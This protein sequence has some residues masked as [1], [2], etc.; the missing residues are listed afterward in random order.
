MLLGTPL[1]F[2]MK[3][4]RMKK[5]RVNHSK[6][7]KGGGMLIC[8]HFLNMATGEW[9]GNIS[10]VDFLRALTVTAVEAAVE[11]GNQKIGNQ[12]SIVPR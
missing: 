5:A 7:K 11:M 3:E 10:F 9:L 8:S 2:K 1:Q 12:L 4:K 6:K